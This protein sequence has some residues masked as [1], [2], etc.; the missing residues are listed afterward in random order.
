M[1]YIIADNIVS[2]LGTTSNQ[3]LEAL[4]RGETAL[5]RYDKTTLG[6][7]ADYMAS[8]IPNSTLVLM[9][10]ELLKEPEYSRCTPEEMA[11]L[12][13]F[14]IKVAYSVLKTLRQSHI[15]PQASNVLLIISTTKGE[16]EQGVH[17]GETA[18]RI[19]RNL[20]FKQNP[21]VVSNACVSGVSAMITADRLIQQRLYA[22]VV[23]CGTDDIG[24]FVVSGFQSLKACSAERCRPFDI[25]RMGLNLGEAV[26]TVLLTKG[27]NELAWRIVDG[28]VKN[29][30][31]HISAPSRGS[32][33]T[34]LCL[35]PLLKECERKELALVNLHGTATVFNDQMESVAVEKVR[36]SD[37]PQNGLKGALGHTL[38]AAGLV[39]SILTMHATQRGIILPT[40][41]YK[42]E[43]TSGRLS[44]SNKTRSTTKRT[45]LKT[46]AGFGGV[47]AVALFEQTA[48][49]TG[50]KDKMA[51]YY[52]CCNVEISPETVLINNAP[53]K[54]ET[55]EGKH[56]LT[57]IYKQCVDDYPKFYKMDGLARLGFLASELLLQKEQQESNDGTIPRFTKRND[58]A[59]VMYNCHSSINA[60]NDY[61]FSLGESESTD[62][63]FPSP[64]VF[65]YTLP[66]IVTGEIAIRNLYQGETE[67]YVLPEITPEAEELLIKAAFADPATQSVMAG[68][69]EYI[70]D[71][72]YHSHLRLFK[73]NNN[74]KK[75]YN[76]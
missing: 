20:G 8:L 31:Y 59:V 47:N 46:L 22:S 38:G 48:S 4:L 56:F 54:I 74:L 53:I 21:L 75:Q 36:L 3:N 45:I 14:E 15:T 29:D 12:S 64:A 6:V 57:A 9:R 70:N 25:D 55:I 62:K 28:R 40:W 11:R 50:V 43:G 24:R 1:S 39:E 34:V 63:Y 7:G 26:A 27:G 49:E 33:G 69:V 58:R 68:Y 16:V 52:S 41:G 10:Q 19:A 51:K 5:Q 67:F 32:E 2:A 73:K 60:D 44:L 23:V 66:N 42:E 13:R 61:I 72:D 17:L 37:I 18:A 71:K 30:A 76:G 35:E 65:V